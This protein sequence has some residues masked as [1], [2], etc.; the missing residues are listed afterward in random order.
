MF[1]I[2]FIGVGFPKCGT[3]WLTECLREHPEI[4]LPNRKHL[5]FFNEV[6]DKSKTYSNSEVQKNMR[7]F[8][9]TMMEK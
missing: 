2:D 5:S 9:T 4:A 3:T 8:I 7:S 1:N 6:L